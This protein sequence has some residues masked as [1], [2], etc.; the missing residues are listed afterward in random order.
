MR[1]H[2]LFTRFDSSFCP[3][4]ARTRDPGSLTQ[5]SLIPGKWPESRCPRIA[6][7]FNARQDTDSHVRLTTH[8]RV[9]I[10]PIATWHSDTTTRWARINV[11]ITMTQDR[12]AWRGRSSPKEIQSAKDPDGQCQNG[13][14]FP[15]VPCLTRDGGPR[16]RWPIQ[17][18]GRDDAC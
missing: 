8:L 3:G 9:G 12:L 14:P 4:S 10:H 11:M 6:W 15:G 5:E 17:C 1:Y 13:S 2:H 16:L 7:S 18:D